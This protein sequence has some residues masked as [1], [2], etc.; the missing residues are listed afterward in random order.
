MGE[1]EVVLY[2]EKNKGKYYSLL[3]LAEALRDKCN[4]RNITRAVSKLVEKKEIKARK[5]DINLARKIYGQNIKRS[6]NLYYLD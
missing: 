2:L 3:E 4:A 1:L 6:L 5:I